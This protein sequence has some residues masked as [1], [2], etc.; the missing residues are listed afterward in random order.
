MAMWT[1]LQTSLRNLDKLL[2]LQEATISMAWTELINGS[3]RPIA[4]SNQSEDR[5]RRRRG[6]TR[7]P[8]GPLT[9]RPCR[10]AGQNPRTCAARLPAAP[11]YGYPPQNIR[12]RIQGSRPKQIAALSPDRGRGYWRAS[13]GENQRR[14]GCP[15]AMRRR[16]SPAPDGKDPWD[17]EIGGFLKNYL[18]GR[19]TLNPLNRIAIH[20][21][22]PI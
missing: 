20:N 7:S 22:D 11:C 6:N 12:R 3:S 1:E 2:L 13:A 14:S 18:G 8:G 15:F 17:S 21:R 16:P 19:I 4:V 5:R 9:V 10:L